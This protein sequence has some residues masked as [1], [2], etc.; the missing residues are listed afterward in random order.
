MLLRCGGDSCF[1]A[2]WSSVDV[3]KL[4]GGMF[5]GVG[6]IGLIN[7]LLGYMLFVGVDSTSFFMRFFKSLK[8]GVGNW[9]NS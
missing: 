1:K 8:F 4:A 2:S 6:K 9:A 3:G 5:G 7:M